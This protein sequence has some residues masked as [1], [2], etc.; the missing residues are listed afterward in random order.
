MPE[1]YLNAERGDRPWS[2]RSEVHATRGIAATSEPTATGVAVDVLRRGGSAVDAAIAANAVLGLAEPTGGGI[3]GDLFA[4]VWEQDAARLYGLNGSGRAP[5]RLTRQRLAEL[6]LDHIPAT[7]PLPVSVPG[8][9]DAWFALHGRFGRLPMRDLLQPAI[10]YAREGIV[11][12]EVVA[13]QWQ[14]NAAL[15]RDFPGFADVFMPGGRA[16]RKGERFRNPDLATTLE[17]VAA[18][19]RDA[20]YLGPVAERIAAYLA[21]QGGCLDAADLAAHRSEWVEP[22]STDYRGYRVWQLPPNGQGV[23]VL[24]LLNILGHFDLARDGFA[25]AR[26][27]HRMLEAT[28]LVYADR[29]MHYADPAFHDTPLEWLLSREYAAGR[30]ALIDDGRAA[31]RAPAGMAPLAADTVY[32]TVADEQRNMVSLIQS[33]YRGMGSGMTPPGL[34]FVL[35][36]R[37]MSFSLDP[38]QANVLEPGKRPFHTIIPGFVTHRGRAWFSFGVMGG[39]MQP[40]GQLQI[41]S[42]LLDHGM[43]AQQAGD[44]PRWRLDGTDEPTGERMSDGG[45]VQL[46]AGFDP[47]L[48]DALAALGHRLGSDRQGFG[49]YQGIRYD[50]AQD[51]YAAATEARK[52]GQAAGY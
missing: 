44:A 28:K 52:D 8:C 18:G 31:E 13:E 49:G 17:A 45:L 32:L 29:A 15:L 20:F 37:G 10:D 35:Q 39:A 4:L 3:G 2:G 5:R 38:A 14:R 41:L 34:G 6:G 30:A 22:L 42:N 19:G 33:N 51:A 26:S 12:G 9:V 47:G 11:I 21:E 40:Q 48:R 7:G 25:A 27:V 23:A 43:N 1:E 16:P 50:A 36:D 24:Q 46:E